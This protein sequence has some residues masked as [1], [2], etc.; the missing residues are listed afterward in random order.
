MKGAEPISLSRY[1][2]NTARRALESI[3]AVRPKHWDAWRLIRSQNGGSPAPARADEAALRRAI[4]WLKRAQDATGN[5]GVSWGYVARSPAR[6]GWP[7]GWWAAYPETTGYIIETMLRYARFA[8]D[9]D[10]RERALR[11][12]EWELTVQLPDGGFQGGVLGSTPVAASTFVTGQVIF[13]LLA[14][15]REDGAARW[16]DAARR[17]G[18]LLLG[19]L[20][21][22]GRFVK[23]HS[24]FCRAGAKAYE[25]RTGW[26]LALLGQAA[27]EAR[28]SGA[29]TQ[30]GEYALSCRQPNGWFAENDLDFNDKPLTHTIGYVLEGLWETGA[31]LKRSAFQE[32]V[33]GTLD[34]IQ[35]LIEESGR[36]AGRWTQNWKPAAAWSCLTGSSQIAL[37]YLR[38]HKACPRPE[39]AASA[40]RLLGF[41]TATQ[42]PAGNTPA[43]VGGIQGSYPFDGEYC[44]Y[45]FPNWAA[46]FY[47]DA[48]MELLSQDAAR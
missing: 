42:A 11:M 38:A 8:G 19:C 31:I 34:C 29:A 17:A 25:V 10:S 26:A 41:V 6:Y 33:L 16:L 5:G 43:L 20:D 2:K 13:G 45:G 14:A 23:G 44:Q 3:S 47:A 27:G 4:E 36:L 48:V 28:Y 18:D 22:R 12:A 39:Y 9:P 40:E 24:H 32:A 30:I 21:D 15:F 46:K 37:T 35:P 1:A 7:T